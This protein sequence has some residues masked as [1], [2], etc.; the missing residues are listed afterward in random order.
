MLALDRKPRTARVALDRAS[1]RRVDRDGRLHIAV[2]NIA[3]AGVDQ[4]LGE[5]IP[6][7]DALGLEPKKIYRM[8]R[9]PKELAKGVDTFN[10]VPILRDHC[11]V[12]ADAPQQELVIGS[13]GTNARWDEPFIQNSA[14]IWVQDDID[15]I[16]SEEK[17]DWSPGYYYTPDMTPGQFN[18]LRFDGVMRDIVCNHV[19]L[20]DEGRQGP[21]VIVADRKPEK[22]DMVLRSRRALYL[23]GALCALVAP[24][25]AQDSK[26]NLTGTLKGVT[27]KTRGKDADKIATAVIKLVTPKLAQD[28]GI[29]VE[30]VVK[31]ISAVDGNA[32]TAPAEDE[33][34]LDEPVSADGDPDDDGIVQDGD[35]DV[36]A[37]VM[38]F[39]KGK[40]SDE[41]M[42]ELGAMLEGN[43]EPAGED[44]GDEDGMEA[45]GAPAKPA[46]DAKAFRKTAARVVTEIREA[47]RAVAPHI[48]EVSVAMDSAAAIYRLALDNAGVD[49]KGV[50]TSAY[51]AMVAML[52]RPAD[53]DV[54]P[55]LMAADRANAGRTFA[56]R[57]PEAN[58][59]IPS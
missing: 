8:F 33:D 26:V 36:M 2:S 42:A 35:E 30:D 28:E 25:L 21:D 22:I 15:D 11:P 52:P 43:A 18:G 48:G 46:M 24:K 39:V 4:Y 13:T 54:V 34:M 32:E 17:R 49:L 41:D 20:V 1:V 3:K 37:K 23:H 31:I 9:D 27:A 40:L 5:E 59:L 14:V 6:G 47:E 19:A 50:P 38:A 56:E 55:A 53:A 29:D 10:N 44:E 7:W 16:E 57:F 45:P 12:D 51:K 58:T